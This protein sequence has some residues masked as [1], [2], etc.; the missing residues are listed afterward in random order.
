MALAAELAVS[1]SVLF[2]GYQNNPYAAMLRSSVFCLSS[3]FE[4]RPLTLA[5]A[6]LLGVPI[7][8]TDCPTGPRE[9]LAGGRYGDLLE[10]DSVDAMTTAIERHFQN[11]QRLFDKSQA[12][13]KTSDS[14]SIHACAQSY[15]AL[16]RQ[17]L[18]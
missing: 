6:A 11:P 17:H 5:E 18:Q 10:P 16:I 8:A 3:R 12:A 7:I 4:G 14:F 2:L 13:K 1:D 9:I 15:T